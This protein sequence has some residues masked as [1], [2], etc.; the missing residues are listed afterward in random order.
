MNI[1][2][3][4]GTG[5]MG[6]PLCRILA[7]RGD[8]V[9]VTSRQEKKG[10]DGLI[11]IKGNAHDITFLSTIL[12]KKRWDAVVDFMK[13]TTEEFSQRVNLLL[14]STNQ[15]VYIS[16]SRVY[17]ESKEALTE[18][19]P[20]L[21]DICSDKEYLSTDEYALAKARQEDVLKASGVNNWTIIR[22]YVTFSEIR[23]Q[24]SPTEKE[25]WLYRALK[26]KS[27]FFSRD[28]SE[29]YTTLT[30]GDDVARSIA[31]IIGKEG[32]YGEAFHITAAESHSW[33][34]ILDN[35]LNVIE[36][37]T[38]KRPKVNMLDHWESIICGSP[39]QVK[40]DRLYD[41]R[42][43]NSKINKYIDTSTFEKTLPALA[44]CL[45]TFIDNPKFDFVNWEMEA[46]RDRYE[47]SWSNL[48]EIKVFRE[49]LHYLR[50]RLGILCSKK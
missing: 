5:A 10:E 3:L 45:A 29:R 47:G 21:L 49:K 12:Q 44:R 22:P 23:L 40:W 32:A 17:A 38:G 11:Y 24:L 28:L 2:V 14:S 26:G 27:I 37:K 42:F 31:A 35:Y 36:E 43:D 20:R 41:R 50:V 8:N 6:V 18:D 30:Y 15:Y 33:S 4:G 7:E 25:Y 39:Y 48:S 16:S 19:S 1:L 9:E 34:E 13:Y 46:K